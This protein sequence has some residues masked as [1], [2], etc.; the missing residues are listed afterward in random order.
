MDKGKVIGIKGNVVEVEF[1]KQMPSIRDILILEN[2]ENTM[3]EVYS[4]ASQN[5]FYALLLNTNSNLNRGTK[6][7]NTKKALSIPVGEQL[8]GR[9]INTFGKA[10]D[11]KGEVST[12]KWKDIYGVKRQGLGSQKLDTI[13]ETGIKIIDFFAPVF[14][15]GKV[16]LFG[17]AG[18]GKTIL[19]TEI[20]HN[21]VILTKGEYVSVFTGV[22]ERVREGQELYESLDESGVLPSVSL[23]FGE[24]SKN[25]AV[26]FRTAF[27]GASIAEYFRDIS[28]KNVLFFIDNV[29]RFA[30]AGNEL[31]TLMNEIPSEG[32]YQASLNSQMADFHERLISNDKNSVTTFEAVYVPSD[33]L[34]DGGVQSIF[35]FLDSNIV[36]SRNIYQQGLFP[37]I[38]ILDSRSSAL[39]PQIVGQAHFNA[40]ISAQQIL[41]KANSLERIVSLVGESELSGEDQKTYKRAKMIRNY[42]TQSFFVAKAQT[43]RDGVFVRLNDTVKDMID[44]TSGKYDSMDPEK[45]LYIGTLQNASQR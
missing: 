28:E 40:V 20:I 8:L 17:G 35:P 9:V 23:I 18:V 19:L 16:G 33:D 2:D 30:Q 26:R 31:S 25:P 37:A 22:G 43:G 3:M 7:I 45:F 38:D 32:G 24:M 10:M 4:S 34:S 6:V 27:A 14:K 13:L 1:D 21:F 42:M 5:S 11:G 36:L 12:D 41:K 44:I 29:F 39:D 15:G